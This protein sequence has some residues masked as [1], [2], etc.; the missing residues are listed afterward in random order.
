MEENL[1]DI[2]ITKLNPLKV[3]NFRLPVV[4][5][6][7]AI[8]SSIAVCYF[9]IYALFLNIIFLAF[10]IVYTIYLLVKHKTL[11][12]FILFVFLSLFVI[13]VCIIQFTT[14]AK[15]Y[16]SEVNLSESISVRGKVVEVASHSSFHKTLL[17]KSEEMKSNSSG[18]L[19]NAYIQVSVSGVI[20]CNIGST[21]AFTANLEKYQFTNINE[22][23]T[24]FIENI[25]Y[26][27]T[28]KASQIE[29][30]P[31][32]TFNFFIFLRA[33]IYKLLFENFNSEV[34]GFAYAMLIG[35][36]HFLEKDSLQNIR[37][38]G[39]AHIFAISG[40]HIGILY[41]LLQF[42]FKRLPFPKFVKF[43]SIGVVLFLYSGICRFSASTLR[44]T[45]MAMLA[46]LSR[47]TFQK[48]DALNTL[49]LSGLCLLL[50]KP[51]YLFSVGYQLSMVAVFALTIIAPHFVRLCKVKNKYLTR[52]LKAIII[53]TTVQIATLPF[54]INYFGYISFFSV[55]VNIVF[56]P[57]LSGTF[58][59]L[60][61]A[62]ILSLCCLSLGKILLFIP[63]ELLKLILQPLTLFSFKVFLLSG[64]SFGSGAILIW[65]L[66]LFIM[67]DK[68]NLSKIAKMITVVAFLATIGLL[69][70]L[71]TILPQANIQIVLSQYYD[72]KVVLLKE[73]N[74]NY[75]LTNTKLSTT[76]L[77]NLFM[78]QNVHSIDGLYLYSD[79]IVY[80]NSTIPIVNQLA[81]VKN[82]YALTD[83]L[84]NAFPTIQ[85]HTMHNTFTVGSFKGN[86]LG[87]GAIKLDDSRMSILLVY[88]Y[89]T[90]VYPYVN[91]LIATDYDSAL[92]HLISSDN[93]FYFGKKQEEG[94]ENIL[95]QIDTKILLLQKRKNYGIYS[96]EAKS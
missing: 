35:D 30:L 77:T 41:T 37:F 33:R 17:V 60:F 72:S 9:G 23:L 52:F 74:K 44:A 29:I 34:A 48:K 67:S 8:L 28:V 32:T 4:L 71:Q 2:K 3:V 56:V 65:I 16:N 61:L 40:L 63:M 20:D 79:D 38:A 93:A 83:T 47:Y 22:N 85:M 54:L 5:F 92:V 31:H 50:F 73:E 42:F 59:L 15:Q 53:P 62:T 10:T 96:T 70:L 94:T 58:S 36:N 95:A 51:I 7:L 11:L 13:N 26:Y 86:L 55:F 88:N 66:T 12:P 24:N 39:V 1:Q 84:Q 43:I 19:K 89:E 87:Q 25:Q 81:P 18:Y 90:I 75:L 46:L 57:I 14:Q 78:R 27:T 64:F 69:F 82:V 49:A 91:L 80:I 21:I 76:F 6:M 68:V 45:I